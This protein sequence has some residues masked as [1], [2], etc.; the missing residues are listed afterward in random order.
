MNV[1]ARAELQELEMLSY[2]LFKIGFL[3]IPEFPLLAGLLWLPVGLSE[4]PLCG[5]G[6]RIT[7]V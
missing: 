5:L 2:L 1:E 7:S 3:N 6:A 4:P